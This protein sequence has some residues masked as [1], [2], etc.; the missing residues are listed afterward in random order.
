LVATGGGGRSR[1][2]RYGEPMP[3]VYSS[4]PRGRQTAGRIGVRTALPN[5]IPVL[6]ARM[7]NLKDGAPAI[8]KAP[9]PT[10]VPASAPTSGSTQVAG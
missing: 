2:G 4:A 9:V 10:P 6:G 1:F 3:G 7:D 8:V 5:G